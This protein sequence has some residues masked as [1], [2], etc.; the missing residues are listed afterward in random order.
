MNYPYFRLPVLL[1]VVLLL[2]SLSRGAQT[3]D[4]VM[5]VFT[6]RLMAATPCTVN[7]DKL[8]TV[9]FKTVAVNKVDNGQYVRDIDYSLNCPSATASSTV[10]LLLRADPSSFDSRAMKTDVPALGV[11]VLNAGV[12]ISLN[13]AMNIDPGNPPKLQAKLVKD[14]SGTLPA[15]A[16]SATGT[17][18]AEYI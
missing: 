16:F 15:R 9:D 4:S 11:Q 13:A 18:V 1:A 17:L 14:P 12:P 5:F 6:G 3:G 8:I 7:G 2:P 10:R